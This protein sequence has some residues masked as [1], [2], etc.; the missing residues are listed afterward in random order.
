MNC[1]SVPDHKSLGSTNCQPPSFR[2][3]LTK[4][5]K[6]CRR[7]LVRSF[8]RQRCGRALFRLTSV[9]S[10]LP[11][12]SEYWFAALPTVAR[13]ASSRHTLRRHAIR[14]PLA[15][16]QH[17]RHEDT[18]PNRRRPT[19]LACDIPCSDSV[20]Q[21]SRTKSFSYWP[22]CRHHTW[23]SKDLAELVARTACDADPF[24][25]KE[26]CRSLRRICRKL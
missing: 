5:R 2:L 26:A 24:R 18:E 11:G 7:L 25:S 22:G 17:V 13:N 12:I 3:Y 6:S 10:E 21:S 19:G 15:R 8:H 20:L 1:L 23:T 14:W 4:T 9:L 16:C